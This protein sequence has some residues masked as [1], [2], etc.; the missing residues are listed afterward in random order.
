MVRLRSNAAAEAP[1]QG[2]GDASLE[3]IEVRLKEAEEENTRL[4]RLAEYRSMFLSRLGHELRTPL[5]SILGFAEI[6]ISQEELTDSQRGF[7]ERI[8]NSAHQLSAILNQLSDLTRLEKGKCELVL[9]ELSID[10]LLRDSCTALSLQARKQAVELHHQTGSNVSL[11]VSDRVK[12][13]QVVYNFIVYAIARSPRDAQVIVQAGENANGILITIADEGTPLAASANLGELDL[14]DN[15]SGY[16][17]L[18]LALAR[19]SVELLGASLTFENRASRGLLISIL[20][21]LAAV[22]PPT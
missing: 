8:Q 19:Q 13:R 18:G 1:D 22:E 11:I 20:L 4:Q 2:N 15:C 7:C 3:T 14:S 10:E 12:L 6:L 5:T 9:E 21:P 16:S 17:E